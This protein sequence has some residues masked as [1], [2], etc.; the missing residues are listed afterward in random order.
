MDIITK[1]KAL[2]ARL[3]ARE[4]THTPLQRALAMLSNGTMLSGTTAFLVGLL[5]GNALI[6]G[7]GGFMLGVGFAMASVLPLLGGDN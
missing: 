7:M 2:Y 4:G 1:L 3:T 5:L 6:A